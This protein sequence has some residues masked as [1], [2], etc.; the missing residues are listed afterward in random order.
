MFLYS[1]FSFC[2]FWVSC[3][4]QDTLLWQDSHWPRVYEISWKRRIKIDRIM[5]IV[6]C[7]CCVCVCVV[8][9][10]ISFPLQEFASVKFWIVGI[11]FRVCS[12][13]NPGFR[14]GSHEVLA[15][16]FGWFVCTWK[17]A[18]KSTDGKVF[19]ETSRIPAYVDVVDAE[20]IVIF[21]KIEVL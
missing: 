16:S 8:Q 17:K 10:Y 1:Q 7:V 11:I 3:D 13:D 6:V 4:K 19:F 2:L 20:E 21:Q 15:W 9:N 5:W 14:D 12:W 18:W